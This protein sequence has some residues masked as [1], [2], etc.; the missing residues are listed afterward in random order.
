M[1]TAYQFVSYFEAFFAKRPFVQ[2]VL[3]TFTREHGK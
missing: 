2:A 1:I 3:A